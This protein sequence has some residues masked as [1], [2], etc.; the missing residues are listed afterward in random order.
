MPT[1]SL[2]TLEGITTRHVDVDGVAIH[3]ASVGSGPVGVLLFHH[4]YG[5]VAT[6]R[7]VLTRLDA[8]GVHAVAVDRPAFGWTERPDP[9]TRPEVYTRAFAAHAGRVVAR[10]LG[11]E[12]LVVVG[13][14]MG[15][16]LALESTLA[17]PTDVEHLVLL[18]P[19]ITGDVGMPATLRPLLRRGPVRR[20]VRPLIRRLS[21]DIDL[22]RATGGWNDRSLANDDD[23]SAYLEPTRLDGWADGIWAVMTGERPPSLLG[24]LPDVEV[25]ATVVAGAHDRIIRPRWNRRTADRLGADLVELDTGHT[26]QEEAPDT[27]VDLLLARLPT[28]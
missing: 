13:S 1:S 9:S 19:A 24:S 6:W 2:P 3:G 11:M 28:A 7:R 12:Q 22:D 23:V 20:A 8:H 16:T 18:S 26:P 21:R 5:N 10:E 15:G 27:I 4:F 25:P 14:S 17:D